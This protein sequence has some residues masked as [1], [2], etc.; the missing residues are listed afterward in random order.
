MTTQQLTKRQKVLNRIKEIYKE[1]YI[2]KNKLLVFRRTLYSK[3]NIRGI[4]LYERRDVAQANN[5]NTASKILIEYIRDDE[6]DILINEFQATLNDFN[7]I[8]NKQKSIQQNL[9]K[10]VNH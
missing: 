9:N 3:L 5:P 10:I 1:N 7:I 2:P 6:A 4:N 8:T